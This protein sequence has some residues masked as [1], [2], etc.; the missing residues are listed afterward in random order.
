MRKYAESGDCRFYEEV[1]VEK[2]C[3]EK[4][5][6]VAFGFKYCSRSDNYLHEFDE[7]V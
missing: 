7:E 5:Y 6:P 4:G 1:E 3:G 2:K